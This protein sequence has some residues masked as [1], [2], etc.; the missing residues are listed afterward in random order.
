MN[1]HRIALTA[2]VALAACLVSQPAS[3]RVLQTIG[4]GA[5]QELRYPLSVALG[6]SGT[7]YALDTSGSSPDPNV[8]VRAYSRAGAGLRSWR[9]PAD[10]L[11]FDIAVDAAENVYVAVR[12][13]RKVLKYSSAGQLLADLRLPGPDLGP[14]ELSLAIDPAGRLVVADGFGRMWTFDAAGQPTGPRQVIAPG[15]ENVVNDIAIAPSGATYVDDMHGIALLDPAG[16]PSRYVALR[17]S[18]PQD[19]VGTRAI[20]AGPDGTVYAVSMR[21]IPQIQRYAADGT[22]LGSV[23]LQR[24]GQWTGAAVAPDGSI[25]ASEFTGGPGQGFVERLAPIASVDVQ[26]PSVEIGTVK[27]R[28]HGSASRVVLRLSYTLSERAIARVTFAGRVDRGRYAGR[29]R[30]VETIELPPA[31]GRHT[32]EWRA[33]SVRSARR[34]RGHYKVFVVASDDAGL[35]SATA[36]ASFTLRRL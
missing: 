33:P 36:R 11:S 9:V 10:E 6:P 13:E 7:V 19:I 35:E 14:W 5:P 17:G 18:R 4:A 23:G 22:Y 26:P 12:S 30:Q 3:A 27:T 1:L 24:G 15:G 32:F 31:A 16:G 29:Y 2:L 8:R 25:L 20:A 28:P 21:R 34:W